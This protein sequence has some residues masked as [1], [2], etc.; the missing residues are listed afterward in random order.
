MFTTSI[1]LD[2]I[3]SLSKNTISQHLGIEFTEV[4]DDY[5]VARMPVDQRTHQ[6]F[7]ILHGGASVVLAETLGSIASYL[8]LKDPE[9]QHA[10]G[11]E[12]NANHIRS[13][14]TGYVYGRVTPIHI[15]RSTQIWDIK[16]TNEE[17]KLVC[18][19]RLTVAI[20]DAKG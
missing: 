8:C 13:V 14:K 7:G 3:H 19:S 18:I 10:V 20:I 11:L 9:K 16:I 4:G 17:N 12:I 15:G 5:L 1:T 6:P 2:A